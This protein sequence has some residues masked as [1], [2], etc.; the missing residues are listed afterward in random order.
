M[1]Q[2][3]PER[4]RLIF[5]FEVP[6]WAPGHLARPRELAESG[7]AMDQLLAAALRRHE[8][9]TSEWPAPVADWPRW[10]RLRLPLAHER[11]YQLYSTMMP[12]AWRRV[13]RGALARRF[14]TVPG[15]VGIGTRSAPEGYRNLTPEELER[16]LKDAAAIGARSAMV[17]RL[18][19]LTQAHAEVINRFAATA[20][21]P[22]R[23]VA[24]PPPAVAPVTNAVTQPR[25]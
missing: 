2:N 14:R 16:D 20:K 19:G 4:L 1:L 25:A 9:W 3:A 5:D 17:Y 22:E 24:V 13:L 18:A 12:K 23:A 10:L 8:V 21:V 7:R 15:G 6:F 11:T